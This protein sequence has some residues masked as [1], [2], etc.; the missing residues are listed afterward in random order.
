MKDGTLLADK[1]NWLLNDLHDSSNLAL[2]YPS[3]LQLKQPDYPL[4][5]TERLKV[6]IS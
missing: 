3:M 5:A 6:K 2:V 1:M 4:W